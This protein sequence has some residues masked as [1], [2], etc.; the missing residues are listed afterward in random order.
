LP[1]NLI[2]HKDICTVDDL[3]AAW[4]RKAPVLGAHIAERAERFKDGM[5]TYVYTCSEQVVSHISTARNLTLMGRP[6]ARF[7]HVQELIKRAESNG[8][9]L[10][11]GL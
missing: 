7:A 1:L 9:S 6:H 4:E 8:A 5:I 3:W 10:C 2:E 11:S